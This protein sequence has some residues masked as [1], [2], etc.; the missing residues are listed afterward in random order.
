MNISPI[1]V[2]GG[3]IFPG[4]KRYFEWGRQLNGAG[5]SWRWGEFSLTEK[6]SRGDVLDFDEFRG[7]V[8]LWVGQ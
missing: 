2:K 6:W 8:Y 7:S 3:L 4:G 5:G 1:R